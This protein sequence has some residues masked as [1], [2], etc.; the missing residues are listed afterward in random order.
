MVSVV[1]RWTHGPTY[2]SFQGQMKFLCLLCQKLGTKKAEITESTSHI[3]LILGFLRAVTK[4]WRCQVNTTSRQ[5]IRQ[6][7]ISFGSI[8]LLFSYE[9]SRGNA[10]PP[11]LND[12]PG[13]PR[14]ERGEKSETEEKPSLS[15]LP[16]PSPPP[17]PSPRLDA[18]GT[19][20]LPVECSNYWL[21][22]E[23]VVIY[24]SHEA[25]IW[26]FGLLCSVHTRMRA[27]S[28]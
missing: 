9:S 10:R 3:A 27:D 12:S 28:N 26:C 25:H 21:T 14:G 20:P 1:K 2:A 8:F 4:I 5:G 23:L 16:P 13:L 6:L 19:T 22:E 18:Q 24:T 15:S 11:P 17:F 7:G